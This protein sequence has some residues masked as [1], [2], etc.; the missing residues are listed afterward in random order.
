MKIAYFITRIGGWDGIALQAAE[1]IDVLLSMGHEIILVIGEIDTSPGELTRPFDKIDIKVIPELSLEYQKY[2]Y[3]TSFKQ[4]YSRKLWIA[5]F[6]KDKR[7]LKNKFKKYVSNA[8][9]VMLHNFSIK[10]LIPS[11]WGAMYELIKES[12]KKRFIS[13][14]A[15]S[16]FERSYLMEKFHPDVLK[17]LSRASRWYKKD[18]D[19]ISKRLDKSLSFALPGPEYL[20]NLHYIV[21]NSYQKKIFHNIYG[22]PDEKLKV[23]HD[24]TKFEKK[25]EPFDKT[26]LRYLENNTEVNNTS[27]TKDDI[28]F[29][30]PVRPVK[31]KKLREIAYIAKLFKH[32][33]KDKEISSNVV[34]VVTHPDKDDN[35]YFKK[36]KSYSQELGVT[37]VYLGKDIRLRGRGFTYEKVMRQFS[38]LNSICIVASAL[39][40]WENGILE[41]TEYCIPVCVNPLLPSFQDMMALGYQYLAA[42]ISI[43]SDLKNI[44]FDKDYLKF[45]SINQFFE[46][47]FSL[48]LDR[49]KRQKHI[50]QNYK[51]GLKK[52]SKHAAFEKIEKLLTNKN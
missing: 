26:F 24:I 2:L 17:I 25:S 47:M 37:F 3:N 35:E 49:K 28:F 41:A 12:K 51:V 23:I 39:G 21:L 36:F 6:I 48:I 15:D 46:K 16:P 45:P 27:F 30:S 20:K 40:G 5:R 44:K 43:F 33:L 29:I 31:R 19:T 13:L 14:A 52:Q 38:K 7:I 11:A 42:P 10:H 22:I 8:D 18:Y 9:L 1:Y 32:Y 50:T 4:Q 34:V